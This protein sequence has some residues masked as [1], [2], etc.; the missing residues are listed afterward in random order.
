[1]TDERPARPLPDVLARLASG[2]PGGS[3]PRVHSARAR[4]LGILLMGA[5][6]ALVLVAAI[7]AAQ[8]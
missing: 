4:L 7:T 3:Y 1:M 8:P 2:M 5:T 6:A